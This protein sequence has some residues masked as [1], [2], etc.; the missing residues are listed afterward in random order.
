MSKSMKID[1][2]PLWMFDLLDKLEEE[3]NYAARIECDTER[4]ARSLQ[5]HW[6]AFKGAVSRS[7]RSTQR[8]PQAA[9]T[10][11]RR[12]ASSAGK[13]YVD[14]M[15]VDAAPDMQRWAK[16]LTFVKLD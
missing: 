4:E 15:L 13:Q 7:E 1:T 8:Y 2:Y 10:T 11:T 14:I 9:Q 16:N 3:P 12:T 6:S 5:L